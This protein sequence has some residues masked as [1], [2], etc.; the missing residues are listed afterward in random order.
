MGSSL[1]KLLA[2]LSGAERRSLAILLLL[3]LVEAGLEMLGVAVVPLYI[4]VLAYP[5]RLIDHPL[6]AAHVSPALRAWMTREHLLVWGGLAMLALYALKT[7]YSVFLGYWRS[8]FAQNR[9]LK[10]SL[11]L[12]SAYLRAPY[13]FHL[14]NN[15]ADLQRN[16]NQ[17]CTQLAVRVLMSMPALTRST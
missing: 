5:E 13:V 16:I 11:R 17:E 15:S 9:A 10:L 2:L 14:R 3:M 8:R 1:A 7:G 12:F 4:T 6:L